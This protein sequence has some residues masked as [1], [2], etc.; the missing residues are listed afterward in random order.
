MPI[1]EYKCGDCGKKIEI[2]QSMEQG[3]EPTN[4]P[5]CQGTSLIRVMS[6]AFTPR[7]KTSDSGLGHMCCGGKR[8]EG[9]VPGE[10]CK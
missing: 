4:C 8:K 6:A 9:C 5:H 10:C 3:E 2:M 1:Y 7:S